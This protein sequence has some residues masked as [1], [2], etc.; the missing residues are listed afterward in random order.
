MLKYIAPSALLILMIFVTNP[1]AHEVTASC[2]DP[3]A[4]KKSVGMFDKL[5]DMNMQFTDRYLDYLAKPETVK[6]LANFQKNYYDSLLEA[7]FDKDQAIAL[8]RDFGN[9]MLVLN[10]KQQN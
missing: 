8:V 10:G 9:P 4:S 3:Q 7:G 1:S 5:F 6:K 2:I